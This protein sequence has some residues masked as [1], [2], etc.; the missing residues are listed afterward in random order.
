MYSKFKKNIKNLQLALPNTLY[1]RF[2]VSTATTCMSFCF[3]TI[4]TVD[5]LA[6]LWRASDK[7]VLTL[8]IPAGCKE[9]QDY[10]DDLQEKIAQITVL[11]ELLAGM[12]YMYTSTPTCSL[13]GWPYH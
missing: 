2:P 8:T 3:P 9:F 5:R 11:D 12:Y 1:I 6:S 10:Y 4:T 7:E 13:A